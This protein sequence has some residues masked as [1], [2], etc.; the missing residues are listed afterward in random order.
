[1]NDVAILGLGLMG[2]SLG[3]A[4]K[5]ACPGIT[6]HGFTRSAARG[7]CALDRGAIDHFHSTPADAV[8]KADIV[9]LCAP[10]LAIPDQLTS[11]ISALKPGVVV[12]DVGS[13]KVDIQQRCCDLLK[14][15]PAFFV[16]SHPIAGSEQ[17]GMEAA[18]VDLY[19]NATVVITPDP[20]TDRVAV[21]RIHTLWT[22]TGAVVVEMTPGEHDRILALTSHLPHIMA[23]LLA[24]TVGR[25][26]L[27]AD[28]PAYCGSGYRDTTRIAGGG[29]DI[30]LDILQTNRNP[31]VEE[32][33]VFRQ[34]LDDLIEK[35]EQ[36]DVSGI[37]R[38][39]IEGKTSRKAFTDYGHQYNSEE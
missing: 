25:P 12:T 10:I 36:N 30:W 24:A 37:E 39:L 1:M 16:G 8:H 14:G 7:Q 22:A 9:V 18:S 21:E 19:Q 38:A 2:G 28:L 11:V 13:T 27:R 6:V 32:M 35:L 33:S 23:T 15:H 5:K 29:V 3:L 26:G 17:Q 4:L 34:K 31:I 20:G